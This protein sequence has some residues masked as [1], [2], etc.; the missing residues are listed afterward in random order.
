MNARPSVLVVA[1]LF[2]S[3]IA[4]SAQ[5]RP[6]PVR[7]PAAVVQPRPGTW[8]TDCVARVGCVARPALP[9]CSAVVT[10]DVVP[11]ALAG[12]GARVMVSGRLRVQA[13]C[14]EMECAPNLCCNRCTA[15]VQIETEGRTLSLGAPNDPAFACAG[16]DSGLCCGTSVPRGVV[17]AVG[18]LRHARVRGGT[19]TI[20]GASLCV[21]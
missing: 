14:T 10:A 9:R 15:T 8:P 3:S 6:A 17:R 12:E 11:L 7:D 5:P 19:H 2:L 1:A 4:S 18:V 13:G 16:D 20:E 21:E